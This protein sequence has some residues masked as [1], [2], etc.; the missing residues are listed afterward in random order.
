MKQIAK[1]QGFKETMRQHVAKEF[2]I[3]KEKATIKDFDRRIGELES[4]DEIEDINTLNFNQEVLNLLSEITRHLSDKMTGYNAQ[5][6]RENLFV[7]FTELFDTS[8]QYTSGHARGLEVI[9][10]GLTNDV[11]VYISGSGGDVHIYM[12]DEDGDWRVVE[13]LK[14]DEFLDSI[15]TD[16]IAVLDSEEGD[17][18]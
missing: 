14:L 15:L 12:S 3:D 4:K 17:A 2:G 9:R 7:N 11:E 6:Q 1:G 8:R 16:V 10:D 18:I 13:R 5:N